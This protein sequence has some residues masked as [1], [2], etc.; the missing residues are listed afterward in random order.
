M[1][2]LE[3]NKI[4]AA[5][6]LAGIIGM[7][8]SFVAKHMVHEE[9]LEKDAYPIEVADSAG[10]GD[11]AAS[12]KPAGPDPIDAL[13]AGADPARG[14]KLSKACAACH[15]FE[16]G[17]AH[18]IGPN[19]WDVVNANKAGKDGF[20]YSSAMA[21]AGGTWDYA[22]LNGFLWKPKKYMKGTK[23]NYIGVKKTQDRAD[24]VAYLRSLSDAP[25]A[26]PVVE[27]VAETSEET[28]STTE[29][30]AH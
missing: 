6:L 12:Q 4:F 14:Q 27:A 2:N 29:A 30:P 3:M 23:M 9:K 17:G 8:S 13:L 18:R 20:A 16:K 21:E 10:H 24:V 1:S 28:P 25:A 15:S 26:L 19:L 22:S 5:V 11:A 7:L